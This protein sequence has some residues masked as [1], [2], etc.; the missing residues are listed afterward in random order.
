MQNRISYVKCYDECS[1]FFPSY[2]SFYGPFVA[3]SAAPFTLMARTVATDILYF[4]LF[5]HQ[6]LIYFCVGLKIWLGN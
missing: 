5:F 6:N 3:L 4:P 1:A 2:L